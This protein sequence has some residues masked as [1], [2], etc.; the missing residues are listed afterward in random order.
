MLG[1]LLKYD[2]TL[3]RSPVSRV[4]PSMMKSRTFATEEIKQNVDQTADL[5]ENEKKLTE[6]I[7]KMSK[8]VETLTDKNKE[9]D[10]SLEEH[11]PLDVMS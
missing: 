2:V 5:T 9:L 10:V 6:E 7:D 3:R 11:G 8:D 4:S 1:K